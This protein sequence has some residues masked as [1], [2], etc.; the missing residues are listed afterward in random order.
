MHPENVVPII[1]QLHQMYQNQNHYARL[2]RSA[3]PRERLR[4]A[5]RYVKDESDPQAWFEDIEQ[6]SF[7]PT[8]HSK[9]SSQQSFVLAP[10]IFADESLII[11]LDELNKGADRMTEQQ[12]DRQRK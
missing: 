11:D 6:H 8:V 4:S 1:A 2:R 12:M 9:S 7:P 5:S 10:K 3:T